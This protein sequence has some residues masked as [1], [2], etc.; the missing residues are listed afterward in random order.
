M[1]FYLAARYSRRI[2]LCGYR[3]NLAALGIEVTSRWLGGGRQLDNQGMPITDTGEQRFEAGDPA[4]DYLRAHFAVEDMAD[5]MAAET[6]VAFTEPPRTAASRGGRHVELGLA[7][8]AGKRVVVVGP[9]ENVFCWL[10]QVEHHD[11]WAGFLA[12][13]RVT[14][15][16]A[17]AGVG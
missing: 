5:V 8:A 16:A 13:M 7:L 3:A 11:R 4:V 12:S 6:L 2:E 10:P 9:R 14:A 1:K 17:K 15:E